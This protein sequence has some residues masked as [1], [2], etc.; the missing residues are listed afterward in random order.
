MQLASSLIRFGLTSFRS[1]GHE[2]AFRHDNHPAS[3]GRAAGRAGAWAHLVPT[4]RRRGIGSPG[5]Q[6]GPGGQV[7]AAGMG[8]IGD[9][10]SRG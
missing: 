4:L 9:K 10:G 6:R 8:E 7:R 5:V 2:S 1:L 3:E